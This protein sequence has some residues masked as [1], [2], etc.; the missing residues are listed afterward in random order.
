MA[1][2]TV[3]IEWLESRRF[4]SVSVNDGVV[5]VIGTP[6]A[7][8]IVITEHSI[9]GRPKVFAVSV[10]LLGSN[11]LVDSA[12]VPAEGVRLVSVRAG[13]GNDVVDVGKAS[14]RVWAAT[15]AIQPVSI[16]AYIDGGPGDDHLYGGK[17][18]DGIFG[19]AGRDEIH[20]MDGPD[21]LVGGIGNDALDGGEDNDL[22]LGNAGNDRLNGGAGDDV[23]LGGE[24]DDILGVSGTM[25][26]LMPEPGNDLLVG[27]PGNDALAGGDGAD[28]IL[29]G[30]G[31]DRFWNGDARSEILDLTPE[32]TI[33]PIYMPIS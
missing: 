3:S 25:L 19:G 26:P 10:R 20:G 27:G 9:T 7:D 11:R 15:E 18:R 21:L 1:A 23:L 33:G 29:G 28:R 5:T 24:G 4:L 6:E 30:A 12:T 22:L 17:A 16:P 32:D 14:P 13:D 31:A 8:D 2:R